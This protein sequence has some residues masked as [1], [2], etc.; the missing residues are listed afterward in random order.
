MFLSLFLNISNVTSAKAKLRT[1]FENNVGKIVDTNTL[2]EVAGI[3]NYARRIRELRDE[4]GMQI[5]SHIDRSDLK[6]GQYVLES[7]ERL[8]KASREISPQLRTEILDRDGYTCQ[9]CGAGP[10]DRDPNNSSRKIRLHIDHIIPKSQ[11]GSDDKDNLR[12]LCST[13]NQTRS[14]ISSVSESSLNI[15]ARLRKCPRKVQREV[16]EVLK[17]TFEG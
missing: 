16:Y 6:P 17:R 14:N 5:R 8:A 4:E 11:G 2:R 15:I 7:K 3:N 9:L 1:F 10:T 12:V 13:C